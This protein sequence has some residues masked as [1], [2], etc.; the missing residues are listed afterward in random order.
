MAYE[1]QWG[2]DKPGHLVFLIDLSGSMEKKMDYVIEVVYKT[3]KSVYAHSQR[4]ERVSISI[5]GY[6]DHI[7]ELFKPNT[8]ASE[9][10]T[11]LYN[12]KEKG[13]SHLFLVQP[14]AKS[15]TFMELAFKK[16]KEDVEKWIKN[17]I[18][19]PN[20]GPNRVPAPI[21]INVTDGKPYEGKNSNQKDVFNRTLRAAQDLMN[22]RTNDGSVR[23][24]NIHHAV[25]STK[26]PMRFPTVR[27]TGD[28]VNE[29]LYDA[30]SSMSDDMVASAQK[31]FN[32]A[33]SGAKCV[34]SNETK[35]ENIIKFLEWGSSK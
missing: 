24:F 33:T 25:D 28:I 22:I 2:S 35:V 17:Q 23:L 5:Y 18:E 10:G 30:S 13:L 27:P 7:Y 4:S 12:V 6:N 19:N 14:V 16:A 1:L 29:F 15:L 11:I 20:F 31:Y 3:C 21:V 26:E 34:I 32:I 9:L 8:T